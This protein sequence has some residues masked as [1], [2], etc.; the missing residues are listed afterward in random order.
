MYTIET[1]TAGPNVLLLTGVHG[2]EY[3]PILAA[4]KLI[5][6][7]PGVLKS[8]TVTS[9][10][11]VNESAYDIYPLARYMLHPLLEILKK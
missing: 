11:M 5:D 7:L 8:G 2:D 10:P 4:L 3:E 1:K 6:Y 9:A